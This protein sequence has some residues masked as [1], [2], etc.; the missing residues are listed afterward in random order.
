MLE[1]Q[2]RQQDQVY[3]IDTILNYKILRNGKTKLLVKWTGYTKPTWEPLME[4][5]ETEAL[6]LYETENNLTLDKGG[7][8]VT[9]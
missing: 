2:D 7:S 4:L 5:L 3:Q 1:Y 6:D 8:I 9:G